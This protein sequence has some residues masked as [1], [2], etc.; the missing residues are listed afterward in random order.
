MQ[1]AVNRRYRLLVL[2]A[3]NSPEYDRQIRFGERY[4]QF[5]DDPDDP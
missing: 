1:N 2:K 4:T 3:E 5:W